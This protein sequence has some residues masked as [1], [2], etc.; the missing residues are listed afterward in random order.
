MSDFLFESIIKNGKISP[1]SLF[2]AT[3]VSLVAGLVIAGSYM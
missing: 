3:A 2:L 1:D